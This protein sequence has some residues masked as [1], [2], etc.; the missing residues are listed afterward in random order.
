MPVTFLMKGTASNFEEVNLDI[1]AVHVK[2][3]TDS[4]YWVPIRTLQ[5]MYNLNNLQNGTSAVIAYDKV[6]GGNMTEVRFV[7]GP[8]SNVKI[9]GV[10]YPL[11]TPNYDDPSLTI[12]IDKPLDK[13]LNSFVIHIDA[14]VS[15]ESDGT[16]KM[17]PMIQKED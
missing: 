13:S 6:P 3:S 16:Y 17:M 9:D 12:R 7:L 4:A 8:N 10:T 2:T 11:L 5:G 15:A 14:G 1:S